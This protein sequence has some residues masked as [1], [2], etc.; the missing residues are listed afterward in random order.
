MYSKEP[1]IASL[2]SSRICHDLVSPLGA[3]SNGLELLELS[4]ATA[5]PE[6]ELLHDSVANA[7]ARINFFRYA[8]GARSDSSFLPESA[9]RATLDGFYAGTR[10]RVI[11]SARGEVPRTQAKLALLVIQC[12]ET[13][14]P[15][16][17]V[18]TATCENGKWELTATDDRLRLNESNLEHLLGK[19]LRP[20]LKPSEIQFE[21]ARRILADE[22]LAPQSRKAD[23][24]FSLSYR[25]SAQSLPVPRE[26][27]AS[28]S[29]N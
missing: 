21:L 4:G 2:I 24:E 16:G 27:D 13:F 20:D 26:T 10:M 11:W 22:K 15:I 18:V 23:T 7:T 8:F 5:G 28:F 25:F 19:N 14:L 29:G 1:D 9:V 3:I 17:G 12:L 6:Y